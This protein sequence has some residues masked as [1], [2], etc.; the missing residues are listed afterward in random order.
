MAKNEDDHE[1]P[2]R[3]DDCVLSES[4]WRHFWYSY[5]KNRQAM[6]RLAEL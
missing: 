3:P 5:N 4:V 6:E 1:I 2:K